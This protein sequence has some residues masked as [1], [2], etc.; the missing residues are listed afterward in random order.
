MMISC[1]KAALICNRTQYREATRFEKLQ[2]KFHLFICKNC[3]EFSTRNTEFTSLCDKANLRVLSE[4][5]KRQMHEN[6]QKQR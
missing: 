5:E 1:K 4:A 6:L 3:L 2:L